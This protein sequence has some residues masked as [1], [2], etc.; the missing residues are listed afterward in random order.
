MSLYTD[1]SSAPSCASVPSTAQHAQLIDTN[2]RPDS[3]KVLG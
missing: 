2:L 1:S 3:Q